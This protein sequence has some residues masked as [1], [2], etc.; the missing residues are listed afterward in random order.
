MPRSHP[1]PART[2]NLLGALALS[3]AD[4]VRLATED[5]SDLAG[6]EPAALVTLA[7]HP[8][9]P[10]EVLRRTLGLTHSGA[11]RL[12]DRLEEAGLLVRGSAGRGR[13][14]ALELTAAGQAVSAR[15]IGERRAA[16]EQVLAPLSA[17]ERAALDPLLGKLL[18]GLTADRQ[19]ARRICRLCDERL[20][21]RQAP[22]PVD[23][24]ATSVERSSR[25]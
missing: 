20:C 21:E 10:I 13:T 5:A 24:A 9:Q 6:G 1:H 18:G 19:D 4:R 12:V 11:V 2:A 3:L 8:D 23:V 16:L 14:L 25:R 17:T 7:Q 22:C 15:V